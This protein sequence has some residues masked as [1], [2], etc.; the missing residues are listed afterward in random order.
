MS[1]CTNRKSVRQARVVGSSKRTLLYDGY[2]YISHNALLND[3][4]WIIRDNF[5]MIKRPI[6]KSMD[7]KR[8]I[9]DLER[10]ESLNALLDHETFVYQGG[11]VSLGTMDKKEEL[12]GLQ[13]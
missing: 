8:T 5:N 3:C 1:P 7:C 2:I 10:S 4:S 12:K 11:F 6:D 9:N 13:D